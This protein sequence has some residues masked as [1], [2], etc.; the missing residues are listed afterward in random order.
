MTL[1][2]EVRS[3]LVTA[4]SAELDDGVSVSQFSLGEDTPLREAIWV[5]RVESVFEWRS[6]GRPATHG[7]RNRTEE[8]TIDLRAQVY[9]EGPRQSDAG[10]VALDR[11]DELLAA[12][13]QA[14][15]TT[16]FVLN[17]AATHGKPSRWSVESQ[18]REKGWLVDARVSTETVHHPT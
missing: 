12:I 8:L 14:Y 18:P 1:I 4:I 17:T 3:G 9:R 5:E 10:Q 16:G 13:E 7:A 11:M 2:A 6:L 15:V